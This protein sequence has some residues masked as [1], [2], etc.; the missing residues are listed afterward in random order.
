M[1]FKKFLTSR[2]FIINFLLAVIIGVA[3]IFITLQVLK[4]Y[5]RHGESKPVPDL[6]GLSVN[7]AKL[8]AEQHELRIRIMDS[9]YVDDVPPGAVVDQVPDKNHR[10]KTNR[11][12][13]LTINSTQPEM[14]SLPK[15]TDISFRQAQV[16][17]EN[18]GLEI[19]Q[20]SYQPSEYN[21]LVLNVQIDSVDIF[22]GKKLA[23][24][25]SVDLIVGQTQG[26][27]ATPLPDLI[28]LTT[29]QAEQ[30]LT[31]ARLNTGV[32]IFDESII[33][34]E[35]SLSAVVWRQRPNPKITG[36]VN[37]GS[38]VDLWVT[39]DELKI[40]EALNQEF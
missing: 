8:T 27:A 31:D 19:G 17:I 24:G 37:L 25:A 29:E 36:T 26:N 20:I 12:I 30:S 39:V 21:D 3:L 40:E 11:T 33:T 32:I 38:S 34:G 28:G 5:T 2:K 14:V 22:P 7:E 18:S 10:V 4:L 15:L 6:T 13:F 23:K 35:D 9:L 16:L 1:S